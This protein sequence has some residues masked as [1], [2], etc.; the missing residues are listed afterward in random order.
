MEFDPAES[1]AYQDLPLGVPIVEVVELCSDIDLI[2]PQG[3][4]VLGALLRE[5]GAGQ[6]QALPVPSPGLSLELQ[7]DP[8]FLGAS[9]GPEYTWEG[10]NCTP[11]L[12][13]T[14]TKVMG[15][16]IKGPKHRNFYLC[17]PA[18]C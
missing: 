7:S 5:F 14:S 8:Q 13:S 16:S 15:I 12:A 9:A 1:G 6:Y 10:P 3:A 4:L 18:A 11:N 17:L 2:L